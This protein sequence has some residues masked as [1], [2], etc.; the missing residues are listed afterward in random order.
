[1]AAHPQDLSKHEEDLLA[2]SHSVL[3]ALPTPIT[4]G[5]RLHTLL[6]VATIEANSYAILPRFEDFQSEVYDFVYV[7]FTLP[8]QA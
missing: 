3:T 7:H 5:V 6:F 8:F 1:M 4:L 2:P